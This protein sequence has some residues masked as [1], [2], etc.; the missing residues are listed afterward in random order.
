MVE[1]EKLSKICFR[2][3]EWKLPPGSIKKIHAC[4]S[5]VKNTQLSNDMKIFHFL[6]VTTTEK[7]DGI[8]VP[9]LFQETII[10][11]F[12]IQ[13]ISTKFQSRS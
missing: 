1:S 4:T 9:V 2:D 13:T 11:C 12:G 6:S 7:K 10:F 3:S 8:I 5:W